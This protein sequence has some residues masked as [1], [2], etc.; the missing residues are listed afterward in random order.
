MRQEIANSIQENF[1]KDAARVVHFDG[2]QLVC[3][4]KKTEKLAVVVTGNSIEQIISCSFIQSGTGK[5]IAEEVFGSLQRWSLGDTICAKCY[6][7]TSVNSGEKN[8]AAVIL[9]RLLGRKL[10][11][12]PC[13]HHVFELVLMTAY[14][15]CFNQATRSPEDALFKQFRIKW[16]E[17]DK[18]KYTGFPKGKLIKSLFKKLLLIVCM[19]L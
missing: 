2:K 8:G 1:P 4:R 3:N 12:F 16:D 9:E 15:T 10:L 18:T 13:R 6:D 17:F 14:K 5:T 7:T 19:S 11:D